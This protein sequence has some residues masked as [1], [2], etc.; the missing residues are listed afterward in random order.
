MHSSISF[1]GNVVRPTVLRHVYEDLAEMAE[2][3]GGVDALGHLRGLHARRPTPARER[4]VQ[5]DG[6]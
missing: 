1:V 6:C 2:A 5:V 3:D 4:I